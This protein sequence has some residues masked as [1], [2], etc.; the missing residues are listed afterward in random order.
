MYIIEW[1]PTLKTVFT[2]LWKKWRLAERRADWAGR[3]QSGLAG[4]AGKSWPGKA[5]V[6]TPLTS[7]AVTFP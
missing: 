1:H 4:G 5:E 7:N 3:D 6:S 2:P